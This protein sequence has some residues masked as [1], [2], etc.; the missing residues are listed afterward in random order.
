VLAGPGIAADLT[1]ALA[2]QASN[3]TTGGLDVPDAY[4]GPLNNPNQLARVEGFIA[5]CVKTAIRVD[6]GG[7]ELPGA[8]L[9]GHVIVVGHRL[10]ARRLDLG[11]DVVRGRRR[12]LAAP[13]AEPAQVVDDDPGPGGAKE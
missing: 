13:V 3:T 12:A 11:H 1:A 9:V 8:L 10:S 5:R 2:E 4:F 6:R 7:N